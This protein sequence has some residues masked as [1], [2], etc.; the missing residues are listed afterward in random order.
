MW[1]I[2]IGRCRQTPIGT[3]CNRPTPNK[4][5]GRLHARQ[6]PGGQRTPSPS[7]PVMAPTKRGCETHT[8]ACAGR[9]RLL[10]SCGSPLPR[11]SGEGLCKQMLCWAGPQRSEVLAGSLRRRK[12]AAIVGLSSWRVDKT[13]SAVAQLSALLLSTNQLLK[14][15]NSKA[16]RLL[17]FTSAQMGFGSG[18]RP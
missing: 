4:V 16:Q 13:D 15:R 12:D 7:S 10:A 2:A 9:Q 6:T 1:P 18:G 3:P 14:G 8:I 17:C 5:S 11:C